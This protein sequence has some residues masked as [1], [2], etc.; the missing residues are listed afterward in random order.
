MRPFQRL[1]WRAEPLGQPRRKDESGEQ[2]KD[3]RHRAQRRDRR[4]I[5][6]H[7]ARDKAHRQQRRNHRQGGKD[8]RIADF[9]YRID[10]T[11]FGAFALDQPA[12]INVFHHHNG[13][14]H[15]DAYGKD[16]CKQAHPVDGKIQNPSRKYRHQDNDR[17]DDNHHDGGTRT[18]RQPDKQGNGTCGYEQLEDQLI[19]L[20]IGGLTIIAGDFHM[21]VVG[22]QVTLQPFHVSQDIIGHADPVGARLF[23]H[24][25]RNGRGANRG[26]LPG[27]LAAFDFFDTH[28]LGNGFAL[29]KSR[30]S[31][32]GNQVGGIIGRVRHQ[33]HIAHID[34]RALAH[35]H[36]QAFKVARILQ[37][38]AGIQ[39]EGVLAGF[40]CAHATFTVGGADGRGQ[41]VK[42]DTKTRQTLG[43]HFDTNRLGTATGDETLRGIGHFLQ[44]LHQVQTQRPQSGFVQLVAPQRQGHHRHI[45]NAFGPNQWHGNAGR[46]LVEVRLHLVVE[47]DQRRA[48]FFADLKLYGDHAAMAIRAGIDVLDALNFAH[49]PFQGVG[50]KRGHLL[51]RGAVILKENVDHRHR[52]LRI[53]LPGSRHQAENAQRQTG[54][55]QQGRQGRTDETLCQLP[56][57]AQ[58]VLDFIVG[59]VVLWCVVCH[60]PAPCPIRRQRRGWRAD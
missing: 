50:G 32:V 20:L 54:D 11:I 4:H 3:H 48:Q 18:K 22:D 56:G 39:G 59:R 1:H 14:V 2:R 40:H 53:L 46:D 35:A 42:A 57:Q 23:R 16:Q 33:R 51:G 29:L 38:G 55:Q 21:H 17:N 36:H 10:R 31:R 19:D 44:A 52:D 24:G 27:A 43:E 60:V 47:L 13:V 28:S 26:T 45:I 30:A 5:G 25:N 49:Q 41:L 58:R 7:H 34:R 8:R 9:A 6:A 37:E 12:P 15:E